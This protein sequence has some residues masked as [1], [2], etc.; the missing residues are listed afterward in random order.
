MQ[1]CVRERTD[2]GTFLPIEWL[3]SLRQSCGKG[4]RLTEE[5]RKATLTIILII[6]SII[7]TEGFPPIP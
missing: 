4:G 5:I 6:T 2:R 1:D 3:M 7:T